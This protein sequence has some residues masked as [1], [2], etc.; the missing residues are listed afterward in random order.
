MSGNIKSKDLSFNKQEPAFL[1]RMRE[2]NSGLG[3]RHERPIARPQ[4]LRDPNADEED[5][6]TYVDEEGGTLSKAEYDAM[7]KDSEQKDSDN[8]IT[9]SPKASGAIKD[10]VTRKQQV[11]DVGASSK[12]RKAAVVVGGEE[13]D[14]GKVEKGTAE[15]GE[16]K[17]PKAGVKKAKKKGK[18]I[19]LSFGDDEA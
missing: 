5:A 19:K 14:E 15:G 7:V 9:K 1:R 12:K 4:R 3:D 17:R 2:A 8:D 16:A 18:P 11:V 6:P 10:E 13:D